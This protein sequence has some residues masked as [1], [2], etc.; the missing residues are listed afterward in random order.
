MEKM[1]LKIV[2]F[3]VLFLCGAVSYAADSSSI[4]IT[5]VSEML[6]NGETMLKVAAKWGGITTVVGAAL[7][8]GRGRLEGALA[9]TICKILI[10]CG[11][12][13]AAFSYF[14]TKITGFAF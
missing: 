7:A 11:L 12:L 6:G 9:Q 5:G 13:I 10:V 4:Q 8:L 14:G 1:I 2:A 3:S